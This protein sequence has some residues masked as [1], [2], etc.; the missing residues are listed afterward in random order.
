[1]KNL[2]KTTLITATLAGLSFGATTAYAGHHDEMKK[3]DIVATAIATDDLSTLVAA[4]TQAGLVETLQGDGPFTVFAPTNAAFDKLPEGTVATLLKDENKAMLTGI[5]TY[6][7]VGA[8]VKAGK[9]TGLITANSGSYAID[10]VNGDQLVASIV[11]GSVILTDTK[12]NT[13]KIIATDIKT[14]NGVVHLIDTVV[15]PN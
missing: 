2:L 8:K 4:V 3:V 5:L 1:M 11:D 13:S 12:G 14:S 9:L 7:V 6:H 15:M 10:T